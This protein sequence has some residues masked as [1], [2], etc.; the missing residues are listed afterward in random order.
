MFYHKTQADVLE[1]RASY[2]CDLFDNASA[3]AIII[4]Q[5]L[6]TELPFGKVN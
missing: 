3:G 6:F 4:S 5:V 1:L 2:N